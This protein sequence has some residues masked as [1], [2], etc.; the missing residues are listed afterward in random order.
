LNS[1]LG[2]IWTR[3]PPQRRGGFYQAARRIRVRL[4]EAAGGAGFRH[5]AKRFALA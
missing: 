5:E 3:A 2:Q 1:P 4:L